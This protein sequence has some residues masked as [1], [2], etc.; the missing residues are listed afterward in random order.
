MLAAA[1]VTSSADDGPGS[2]RAAVEAANAD[3]SITSIVFDRRINVIE[4]DEAVT[5]TGEQ[6]LRIDGNVA[7]IRPA[8][9]QEGEID[10]FIS[11]GG[12]DLSLSQ[13]TFANGANG[14]V[15]DVPLDATGEVKVTLNR[16]TIRD[17]DLFGLHIIDLT[18]VPPPPETPDA[19]PTQIG[20]DASVTLVV[21]DSQILGNGTAAHDQ[22]GIRVDERGSGGISVQIV[23]SQLNGN[24]AEGVELDEGGAGGVDLNVLNS[25]FNGNG[26]ISSGDP[27]DPDFDDGIDVDE[28]DQGSVN[29]VIIGADV[30]G[31]F[32][33][34][35]DLNEG[36]EG[37]LN[38][39]LVGVQ[40]NNNTDEGIALE[41]AGDGG[42]RATLI[43]VRARHNG[44]DGVQFEEFDAGD[45][46][47][48]IAL[49]QIED[50]GGFG[51]YASQTA[52]GA[53]SIRLRAVRLNRN[54]DGPFNT[55]IENEE[56]GEEE[57][58][59]VVVSGR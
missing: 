34:G 27:E 13:L 18:E 40:A 20:A 32:D 45:I 5:Y 22:D 57:D 55:T 25:T 6:A 26:F 36:D 56:T 9:D 39:L 3:S 47:V 11:S 1:A 59:G 51:I 4:L 41:E 14:V 16:V 37:D 54:A 15:V 28:A 7:T 35:I 42:I 12:A 49:S 44:A 38:M 23:N 2:F 31:N 50:N 10:L 24:G 33:E 52:P 17:N 19:D 48:D 58:S 30:S 43:T 46:A 21:L 29:A 53:G 8:D